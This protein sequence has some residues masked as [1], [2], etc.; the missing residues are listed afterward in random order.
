M[1][2][3]SDITYLSEA[4]ERLGK[5]VN[6]KQEIIIKKAEEGRKFMNMVKMGIDLKINENAYN[7]TIMNLL[8]YKQYNILTQQIFLRWDELGYSYSEQLYINTGK[9]AKQMYDDFN[10]EL[11]D[12]TMSDLL[13]YKANGDENKIDKLYAIYEGLMGREWL[14]AKMLKSLKKERK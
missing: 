10:K 12:I 7:E 4:S 2:T 8:H 11:F 6:E 13:F 1:T 5:D 14:D 9:F 3:T